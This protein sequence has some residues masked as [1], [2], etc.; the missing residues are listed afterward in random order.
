MPAGRSRQSR[1]GRAG[2]GPD[3]RPRRP[4]GPPAIVT[5]LT[6]FGDG[7]WYVAAMKSAVLV[8]A[9][10]RPVHLIDVSH[11]VPPQDVIA[12]SI[13][14]ERA[15]ASFPPGT[16][17]VAVVD[18]GVGTDRRL[19]AVRVGGQT[20]LCPDN[21]LIT[22]AWRRHAETKPEAR[23]LAWRPAGAEVSNT[24]HGRDV[25]APAAG[26]LAA[27]DRLDGMTRTLSGPLLL[28]LHLARAE[29]GGRGAIVHFDHYGNATTNVPSE[30]LGEGVRVWLGRRAVGP[31]RRTYGDVPVGRAL[32]LV[33]SSG[34]LEI[35]VRNGSAREKLRLRVG[36][37]VTFGGKSATSP[38]RPNVS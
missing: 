15:V 22:W 21:G 32:A 16:I 37:A 26:R 12:G 36:D 25:L 33:G 5:F 3:A 17:H 8:E 29:D 7:D 30:L 27:G 2:A 14:L 4:A 35:A 11:R 38:P 10:D 18:P 19:L 6:D 34:L 9:R 13:L 20:V 1:I 28:D 23:E 31:V 24:F